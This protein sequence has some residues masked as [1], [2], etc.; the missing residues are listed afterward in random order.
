VKE[1]E[2]TIGH[3]ISCLFTPMF[4]FILSQHFAKNAKHANIIIINHK[5]GAIITFHSYTVLDPHK[6]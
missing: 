5:I 6:I 2:K 1:L 4:L 3:R